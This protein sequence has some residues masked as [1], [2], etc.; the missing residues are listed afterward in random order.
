[1]K[2]YAVV[3]ADGYVVSTC[4]S[5]IQPDDMVEL[6]EAIGDAPSAWHKYHLQTKQWVEDK[7]VEAVVFEIKTKRSELLVAS[8]WTQLPNGPLTAEQT[9]AWAT[10]RQELRD[11]PAQSGYPLNVIWP[12]PP[13]G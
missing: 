13:Q 7:P 10:Y 1:M 3:S 12:T 6:S 11:I 4:F 9:T 2:S 8:D 5:S